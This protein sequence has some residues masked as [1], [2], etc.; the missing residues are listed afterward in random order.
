LFLV[1][2]PSEKFSSEGKYRWEVQQL[3]ATEILNAIEKHPS[4][5]F[6]NLKSSIDSLERYL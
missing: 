3:T 1:L 6:V 4:V 5:A 2:Y